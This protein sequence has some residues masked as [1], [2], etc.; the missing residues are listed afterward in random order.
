M[1]SSLPIQTSVYNLCF[2]LGGEVFH[3]R[4]RGDISFADGLGDLVGAAGDVARGVEAGN[5]GFL[6][7]VH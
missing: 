5:V 3:H 2:L 4:V 7:A 6:T 1:R